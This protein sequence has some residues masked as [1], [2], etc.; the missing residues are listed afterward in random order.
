M[1]EISKSKVRINYY[2]DTGFGRFSIILWSVRCLKV[3]ECQD[4]EYLYIFKKYL[5]RS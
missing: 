4:N 5:F 2:L 3:C 1:I